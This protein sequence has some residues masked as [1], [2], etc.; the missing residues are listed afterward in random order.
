MQA[1]LPP[2]KN[3]KKQDSETRVHTLCPKNPYYK[4]GQIRIFPKPELR[5]YWGDSLTQP[6]FKVTSA[7]VVII[8]PDKWPY[9]WVTGVIILLVEVIT[10][11]YKTGRGPPCMEVAFFAM[12]FFA[13]TSGSV[14]HT[15]EKWHDHEQNLP[16]ED[17]STIKWRFLIHM[18][19]FRRVSPWTFLGLSP[20]QSIRKVW[21]RSLVLTIPF[22][23]LLLRKL[24]LMGCNIPAKGFK[25][26]TIPWIYNYI[27]PRFIYLK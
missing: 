26:P 16:F 23:I 19:V 12:F 21:T 4:S 5:G 15:L 20:P 9:K 6:Q 10:Q 27:P 22:A 7:E 1:S 11:V 8:C 14:D 2:K 17:A 25:N 18:L 24:V 13:K 3:K